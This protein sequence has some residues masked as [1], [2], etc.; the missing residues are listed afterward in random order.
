MGFVEG[1]VGWTDE[2]HGEGTT[3][4]DQNNSMD[5]ATHG[6]GTTQ[7]EKNN[8]NTPEGDRNKTD[9]NNND[10]GCRHG[11]RT[12]AYRRPYEWT[13]GRGGKEKFE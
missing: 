11:P 8:S 1:A 13:L 9:M 7:R 2:T 3:Q 6:E 4:R 10:S 5:Q 12:R